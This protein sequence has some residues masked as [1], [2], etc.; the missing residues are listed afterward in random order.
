MAESLTVLDYV[1][2]AIYRLGGTSAMVDI[3]DVAVEAHRLAPDRFRW[4]RHDYP[5]LE[6]VRVTTGPSTKEAARLVLREGRGRMLTVEGAARARQVLEVLQAEPA[7]RDDTLRRKDLVD[8]SRMEAH[9]AFA[10]WRAHGVAGPDA[11]DLADLVR[12]SVSTPLPV[13]ED[14]LR[15][16]AAVAA[17]WHREELARFLEESADH[18]AATLQEETR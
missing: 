12:C 3:E 17:Q 11:V 8:V 1:L 4:R 7:A 18:L 6:L 9:P 15:R 10:A 2:A 5:N 14:R 16:A 13:F